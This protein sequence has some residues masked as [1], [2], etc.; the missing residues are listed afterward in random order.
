[1]KENMACVTVVMAIPDYPVS[2]FTNKEVSD[3]PV[4]LHDADRKS[5]HLSEVKL[6]QAHVEVQGRPVKMPCYVTSGDY[7]CVVSG[8]GE[9][10]TGARRS[11]YTTVKK[12][13]MPANPFYRTDIG[14]YGMEERLRI[15][16][17]NGFA[18]GFRV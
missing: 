14:R 17:K 10:I 15:L 7:V 3:I 12:I 2:R 18:L 11:A 8:V 16:Q 4:Y 5:V 13:K 9:T 6:G 1:V